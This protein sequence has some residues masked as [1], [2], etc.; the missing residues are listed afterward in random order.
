MNSSGFS[1]SGS[2]ALPNAVYLASV[3]SDLVIGT[4]GSNSIRWVT[5]NSSTDAVSINSSGVATF[6]NKITGSI[7]GNA[8]GTSGT[9]LSLSNH[10]TTDLA[11]GTNKYYLDSRA[12]GAISGGTG[13]SYSS[14]D[15]IINST[16]TQYTDAQARAA[17]G[18]SGSLSY[19]SVSGIISYTT[20]TYTITTGSPSG[21][22]ALS[23]VGTLFTFNPS[24]YVGTVTGVGSTTLTI[25][26]TSS[27]PTVNLTS[28]IVTAGTTGS[29]SLV[30]VITVDTY[31]RITAISTAP[32]PQGTVTGIGTTTLTVGGTSTTPTVN[33]T[34]GIV[35]AGT[36]GSSS[37]VPVVT[38]DTY[39][40]I[41]AISTA[42]NPQGTV[43]GIGTTTL[44]VGGTS[45]T[46]TVNLTSGIV[47]AGTT[48]SSSLVPVV[49][50]DTYGRITA[51]STAANP[52]GTVTSLGSTTLTIGG[53]SA[54]PTV[55]LTSGIVTAGTTGSSSLIPVVTLDTYGRVTAIT[56]AA[57][58]QGTVTSITASTTPV[59][60]LS[61]SG[62]TITSTGTVAIT[63]TLSGI[64]N[65][66]LSG[67]AGITNANLANS[68]IS[69]VSL[70]GSLYNLTAGTGISFSSGS[71]YN[72]SAAITV[73]ANP[74]IGGNQLVFA[75][76]SVLSYSNVKTFIS[77][78]GLTNGVT[79][80]TNTRYQYELVFN[81]QSNK[82]GT[83]GYAL[84][85]GG[86]SAVAQHNY[87]V[88]SNKTITLI[89]YTA[90]VT[91]MSQNA[92]G[93]TITTGTPIADI[94]NGFTH[95]VIH[96]TIDVTTG[97]TVN[98]MISQD[99][100]AV[101]WSI[102]PGAYIKLMPLG[103]IGANTAA[104]TWS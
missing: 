20:P 46:P 69:G 25:G 88:L 24:S 53:T 32:N 5:N 97:G 37:L 67:T 4:M 82:D 49:T 21:A 89:D 16:I 101:T 85:L 99:Q 71:T 81:L 84:A 63:G 39:G 86:S 73:N 45:T 33:L 95:F 103:A 1:G 83:L 50:V 23:L 31:G 28:G 65:S 59:N 52:Q 10:T 26:G 40:R 47:V 38:V 57:N 80:E 87:D 91:M 96:G 94:K 93:A 42:P 14:L 17:I 27:T 9:T 64:T 58:P 98:F 19:N 30:P 34:S 41:T 55:N 79:L 60:G 29:S 43:T 51:I 62:G 44:T 100:N 56:T 15:G 54:T 22:G 7:S 13:I 61:L 3:S 77:L 75:L 36:T 70:G 48:G 78:F 74:G 104:G 102:K 92:T 66:N 68:T 6:A 8:D 76:N 2:F 35:T 11:E 72:G 90:G 12:R 18:V